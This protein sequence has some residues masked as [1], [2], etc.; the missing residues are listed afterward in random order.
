MD[1]PG[2]PQRRT[3]TGN[4]H[5]CANNEFP[6]FPRRHYVRARSPWPCGRPYWDVR[7]TQSKRAGLRPEA[8]NGQ[9]D[10]RFLKLSLILNVDFRGRLVNLQSGASRGRR[11][12]GYIVFDELARELYD[13]EVCYP[14]C[15]ETHRTLTHF[16]HFPN[17]RG[18]VQVWIPQQRINC[19]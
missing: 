5:R 7:R 13:R 19:W 18:G 8:G 16:T 11:G 17:G 6:V 10:E 4:L 12:A 15:V 1:I 14:L 9:E 3:S 2:T